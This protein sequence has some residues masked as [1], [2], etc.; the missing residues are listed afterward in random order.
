MVVIAVEGLRELSDTGRWEVADELATEVSL[1][2]R[3]K[4]RFDDRLGRFDDS[5][6]ILLLRRVDSELATLIVS[7]LVGQLTRLCAD[8]ERWHTKPMV[9]CGLVGSGTE[10]PDLNTL[11]F[12][13]LSQC[14]RARMEDK[15]MSSDVVAEAVIAGAIPGVD[16]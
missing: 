10:Q 12:R 3:R 15:T 9:R 7:Q 1:V 8:N 2:L 11:V 16:A 5:Q 6:F 4:V 14:R 13:A